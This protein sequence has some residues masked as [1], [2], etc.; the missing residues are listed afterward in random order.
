M[1]EKNFIEKEDVNLY[2]RFLPAGNTSM[3]DWFVFSYRGENV[4]SV[5]IEDERGIS[6]GGMMWKLVLFVI[7][8]SVAKPMLSAKM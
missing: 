1:E 3:A 4:A 8:I 5:D 6:G 7:R 2:Y